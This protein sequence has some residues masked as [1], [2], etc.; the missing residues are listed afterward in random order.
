[1]TK[2]DVPKKNFE[3][4]LQGSVIRGHIGMDGVG[5]F[6]VFIQFLLPSA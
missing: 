1:M 5:G 4:H 6:S 2:I 3:N